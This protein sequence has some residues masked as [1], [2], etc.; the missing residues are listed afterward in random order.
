MVEKAGSLRVSLLFALACA[1]VLLVAGCGGSAS[2]GS[3]AS[4]A[5]DGDGSLTVFAAASLTDAFGELGEEFKGQTGAEITFNFA[6]SS[7]LA[8]QIQQGAPADVFAAADEVQMENVASEDLLAGDAETFVENRE[9]VVVPGDN[10][11]GIEEFGD[12]S[13]PDV[14]LVLALDEVPAA[15]YA[16]EI[17]GNASEDEEYGPEFEEAVLGNIVSRE[18]DVRAAVNR[19]VIGDADA[20]F[21][22]ASDVTPDIRDEVEVVEVPEDLQVVPTY[23]IAVLENS[24][25]PEL[26]RAWVDLVLSEE[27]Q[28]IF[29]DWGFE[30]VPR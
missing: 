20:T 17:L 10:P 15:E 9:V 24:E 8:T 26:A 14:R 23:Q 27:G 29:E 19:V 13:K 4:G 12:L 30:P 7:V 2:P 21:G 11:A 16:L 6:G 22:Y 18:E 5:A 28:Q 25:D 3:E 1:L